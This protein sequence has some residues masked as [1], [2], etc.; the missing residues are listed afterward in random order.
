MPSPLPLRSRSPPSPVF[1]GWSAMHLTLPQGL[2]CHN[3]VRVRPATNLCA[4]SNVSLIRLQSLSAYLQ[5][6]SGAFPHTLTHCALN[7]VTAQFHTTVRVH[8]TG[9]KRTSGAQDT[10]SATQAEHCA[11]HHMRVLYLSNGGLAVLRRRGGKNLVDICTS[12]IRL[13]LTGL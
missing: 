12:C 3:S 4:F 11:L 7:S 8:E 5:Y 9:E 10:A 6:I 1:S 2:S 13:Y